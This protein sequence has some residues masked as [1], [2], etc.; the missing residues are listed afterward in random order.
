[1]WKE[2]SYKDPINCLYS[3]CSQHLVYM[4]NYIFHLVVHLVILCK[5]RCNCQKCWYIHPCSVVLPYYEPELQERF[6]SDVVLCDRCTSGHY[7]SKPTSVLLKVIQ[8]HHSCHLLAWLESSVPVDIFNICMWVQLVSLMSIYTVSLS[9]VGYMPTDA[10]SVQIK[11][12]V[13]KLF[14]QKCQRCST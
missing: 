3:K 2:W 14:Q 11:F 6:I 5:G 9:L 13:C 8:N 7:L 4:L 12:D 10:K 1:M